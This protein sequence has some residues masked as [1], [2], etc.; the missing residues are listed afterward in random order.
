MSAKGAVLATM[1][2]AE[3]A[4]LV[5][6]SVECVLAVQLPVAVL[7]V[8]GVLGVLA[9]WAYLAALLTQHSRCDE[10]WD[11][12]DQRGHHQGVNELLDESIHGTPTCEACDAQQLPRAH[13]CPVC[14]TC[15]MRFELHSGW[16]GRCVGLENLKLYLLAHAYFALFCAAALAV[17][18]A[19]MARSRFFGGAFWLMLL[20][21]ASFVAAAHLFFALR[22]AGLHAW[23]AATGRTE[24][25]RRS[26]D[27]RSHD[28]G[29]RGNIA[30][31]I[32]SDE[33][34][35]LLPIPAR[36]D[37]LQ[38]E[39]FVGR[40]KQEETD[41]EA[42]ERGRQQTRL[43]ATH[44]AQG[45]RDSP[46]KSVRGRSNSNS[47]NNNN[48]NSSSSR[49]VEGTISSIPRSQEKARAWLQDSSRFPRS[50]G[51]FLNPELSDDHE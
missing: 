40:P 34:L 19:R 9:V 2:L 37:V 25:E 15:V 18:V 26:G 27:G 47:S 17:H 16:L 49:A 43:L 1:T 32:G 20:A 10:V 50:A 46:V 22:L 51:A 3:V 24:L 28:V 6:S 5:F 38:L 45:A 14:D 31:V 39:W 12:V 4:L 35:A 30:S 13:H 8:L 11:R 21:T 33:A 48:N 7:A 29:L 42:E 44:T 23:L 41:E 36:F